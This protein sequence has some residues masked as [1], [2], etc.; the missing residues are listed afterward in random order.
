MK[1]TIMLAV[2]KFKMTHNN[3]DNKLLDTIIAANAQ[4]DAELNIA[5]HAETH[6]KSAEKTLQ[7]KDEEIRI[8]KRALDKRDQKIAK[9]DEEVEKWQSIV[10]QKNANLK[11]LAMKAEGDAKVES[12]YKNQLDSAKGLICELQ[13]KLSAI[14]SERDRY[15]KICA[16]SVSYVGVENLRKERDRYRA[17]LKD[18]EG[19]FVACAQHNA[20][21]ADSI[22]SVLSG[23]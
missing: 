12:F 10:E 20:G 18:L 22:R 8:L 21:L 7:E 17:T 15:A 2:L 13:T 16:N 11:E 4:L 1:D 5:R 23:E 14:S 6:L 19:S 9:L 3:E